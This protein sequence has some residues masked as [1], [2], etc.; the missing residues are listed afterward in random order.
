MLNSNGIYIRNCYESL[1]EEIN[2][3]GSDSVVIGNPGIGKTFFG[4]FMIY[5]FLK[6]KISFL[7]EPNTKDC[8]CYYFNGTTQEILASS[9]SDFSRMKDINNRKIFYLVDG[10]AAPYNAFKTVLICS[11]RKEYYS[12][13]CK[14]AARFLYMPIWKYDCINICKNQFFPDLDQDIVNELFKRWGGVP[15]YVLNIPNDFLKYELDSKLSPNSNK[16]I[17]TTNDKIIYL[18]EKQLKQ[19]IEES[20]LI[21]IKR[22]E[23]ILTSNEDVSNRILHIIVEENDFLSKS[24]QFASQYVARLIY[25]HLQ[26]IDKIALKQ[27]LVNYFNDKECNR[28]QRID[29]IFENFVH[30]F[31]SNFEKTVLIR[32][33][34]SNNQMQNFELKLDKC[35]SKLDEENF[36]NFD[37]FKNLIHSFNNQEFNRIYYLPNDSFPTFDSI[38][39]DKQNKLEKKC[40]IFNMTTGSRHDFK[41]S[42][43]I[44]EIFEYLLQEKFKIEFYY[45]VPEINF[46]HFHKP[47]IAFSIERDDKSD[48]KQNEETER[49]KEN[50][51]K[52]NEHICFYALQITNEDILI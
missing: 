22:F 34:E 50:W 15:R 43:L 2:Q 8:L 42:S 40:Q 52:I 49:L 3:Y 19:S 1:Y 45:A 37:E 29:K 11:P 7:F 5:K 31:I 6:D 23:G 17:M 27:E 36:K 41:Y 10:H 51:I 24:I 39:L 4:Y 12:N 35:I 21:S 18:L 46:K 44:Q 32:H 9:I 38:V 47:Q 25:R 33:L 26:S 13:I 30:D 20:N 16:S 48:E 28:R 14:G